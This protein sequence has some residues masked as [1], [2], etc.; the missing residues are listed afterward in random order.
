MFFGNV[1]CCCEEGTGICSEICSNGA[2]ELITL[3]IS[4]CTDDGSDD[5]E[6]PLG[7]CTPACNAC[8]YINDS[9]TLSFN[10]FPTTDNCT[11]DNTTP[12][13]GAR[14][15]G[16]LWDTGTEYKLAIRI[17]AGYN[18]CNFGATYSTTWAYGGS[19]NCQGW[20]SLS[21][22]HD[23]NALS[24]FFISDYDNGGCG[25]TTTLTVTVTAV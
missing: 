11:V 21:L 12:G 25:N 24:G 9:F 13:C 18:T 22:S 20:S 17:A 3:T 8:T 2:P 16:K 1:V 5:C 6:C 15:D 23:A 7:T 14:F 4:G 19:V 10:T